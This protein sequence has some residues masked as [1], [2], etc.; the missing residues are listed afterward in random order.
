MTR[1]PRLLSLAALLA[2]VV[3]QPARAD[4][5]RIPIFRPTTIL[6]PGSYVVTSNMTETTGP[7][8]SIQSDNVTLD[9]NGHTIRSNDTLHYAIQIREGARYIRIRNGKVAGGNSVIGN[10]SSGSTAESVI[11][12]ENLEISDSQYQAVIILNPKHLEVLGCV[13]RNSGLAFTLSGG[14]F[15]LLSVTGFQGAT[16]RFENNVLRDLNGYGIETDG[17][18]QDL[19]IRRNVF[20]NVLDY[21]LRLIGGGA[22]VEDNQFLGIGAPGIFVA[23]TGVDI[24]NNVFN[25]PCIFAEINATIG[26]GGTGNRIVGNV[27]NPPQ[28]CSAP[29]EG[30]QIN[31]AR[32]LIE[33]NV[34]RGATG[35]AI[36]F[37]S[38]ATQ[39]S[40]RGNMLRGNAGGPV[41]DA[42]TGNTDDGGNV[43]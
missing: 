6:Q 38:S 33:N 7:L 30:L 9:L 17:V 39:N 32:N 27:H 23:G 5:S 40:Y 12:L 21:K 16:A 11:T 4:E 35:C 19:L 18:F 24:T 2:A 43:Y 34:I 1:G 28:G 13:V 29:L 14:G 37:A 15:G 31:S 22:R 36:R 42:G 8:I 20:V 41:C 10:L 25:G 3:A 26:Q